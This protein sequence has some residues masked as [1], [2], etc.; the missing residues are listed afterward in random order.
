MIP[1]SFPQRGGGS[2]KTAS[3]NEFSSTMASAIICLATNQKFNFSRY[4][5]V[6]LVKNIEAGV[7][8]FMCPRL[9]SPSN[10]PLLDGEDNLKLKELMDLC[11]YFSN[12]VLELES[13]VIDIKS[14]YK[15]RIEK[16]KGRVDR[17]EEENRGRI[18]AD[19]EEDIEINLEEDQAKPYRMDLEHQEKVL[20]TTARA[21]T[22]AK[23]TKVSV[24]RRRIGVV[25]QDPKETTSTVVVHLEVQS[26]DKGKELNADI[27][28]NDVMEQVKRSERLN[29][30]VM[31]YQDINRKPLTKAQARKNMIIYLKNMAGFKMNYFKR[32][33]YSGRRPLFE[34]HYNYN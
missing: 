6:I 31:K 16:I 5:L 24:P 21:T 9:P 10:D 17:L 13:E 14:T 22:T 28:W 18:I 30:A 34:K 1:G 20:I 7:P 33:T 15:E 8:F 25:I 19:I 26:K 11:T 23:A 4:I 12:K 29:D 3:W 27:N 32:M 2:A